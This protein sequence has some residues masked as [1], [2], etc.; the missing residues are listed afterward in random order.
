MG[1]VHKLQAGY[2]L[3]VTSGETATSVKQVQDASIGAVFVG[4]R[5]FG[6]YL[7][8]R[9]FVVGDGATVTMSASGIATRFGGALALSAGAPENAVRAALLVNP[10]GD[11]NALTFTAVAYGSEGN[12]IS[13]A[14]V[15]PAA[16]S[17]ALA[18]VVTHST[19]QVLLATDEGGAIT[20]TAAQVLAGVAASAGASALVTATLYTADTGV[21]DDGSGVVTAMAQAS[22]EG[23][24]GTGIN[25][26]IKGGLCLD[27]TNGELY[28]N[29]G[30][31]AAP[32]WAR[33]AGLT[34]FAATTSTVNAL[35]ALHMYGAGAP[36]DYTDGTPPATGEGS[37]PKGAIYSDTTNGFVYRNSGSQAQPIWTKLGDAV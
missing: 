20:S 30:T 29:S 26:A 18:V 3:G 21:A 16:A 14:Y 37:A 8:E 32:V 22:L 35:S 9:S 36:V 10:A 25:V 17:A 7:V 13:V 11:D 15:D 19:I 33:F 4:T 31:T 24:A 28:L 6:P 2:L 34:A 12:A 23:G 27:T 1:T 5:T